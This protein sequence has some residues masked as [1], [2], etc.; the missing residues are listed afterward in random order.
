M[1]PRELPYCFSV[2]LYG[3]TGVSNGILELYGRASWLQVKPLCLQI[4]LLWLQDEQGVGFKILKFSLNE[5]F[6]VS[7]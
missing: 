4:E 2:V 6:F 5:L 3:S 7:C 1:G